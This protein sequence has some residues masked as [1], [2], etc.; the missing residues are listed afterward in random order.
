[1]KKYRTIYA[2]EAITKV[3]GGENVYVLDK[4]IQ[5]VFHVNQMLVRHLADVLRAD[6]DDRFMFWIEESEGDGTT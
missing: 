1:M 2:F 3:V 5:E 6:D 4:E